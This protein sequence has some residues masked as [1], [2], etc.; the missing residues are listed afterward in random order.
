M[1]R[2]DDGFWRGSVGV[3]YSTFYDDQ[4][5][6]HDDERRAAST[7]SGDT[8][9]TVKGRRACQVKEHSTGIQR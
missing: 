6:S 3:H 9:G 2:G 5:E 7:E 4:T 8:H 1:A